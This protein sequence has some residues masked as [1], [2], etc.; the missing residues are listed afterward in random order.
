MPCSQAALTGSFESGDIR[1]TRAGFALCRV[2]IGEEELYKACKGG[3]FAVIPS[4]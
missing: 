4:G 2:I 3:E 1:A